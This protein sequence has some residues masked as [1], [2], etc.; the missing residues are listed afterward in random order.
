MNRFELSGRQSLTR[1]CETLIPF[2]T[3]GGDLN[4][5]L[6]NNC[7]VEWSIIDVQN[8]WFPKLTFSLDYFS[9]LGHLKSKVV[10]NSLKS[11]H[12]LHVMITHN[13]WCPIAALS[14]HRARCPNY[15]S[16]PRSTGSFPSPSKKTPLLWDQRISAMSGQLANVRPGSWSWANIQSRNKRKSEASAPEEVDSRC[17]NVLIVVVH[18]ITEW[19]SGAK[20]GRTSV[21]F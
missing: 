18:V 6:S 1:L 16:G 7:F 10:W 19:Q 5:T 3:V 8:S 13:E 4:L 14:S 21:Q 2:W 15:N 20:N 11:V 17:W 12:S 9:E